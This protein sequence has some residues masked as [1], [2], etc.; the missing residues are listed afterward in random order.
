MSATLE[1][2]NDKVIQLNAAVDEEKEKHEKKEAE[3]K[4]A[5]EDEKEKHKN[6]MKE[7]HEKH[8][9][10]IEHKDDDHKTK[11]ESLRASLKAQMDEEKDEKKKEGLKAALKAMED[12]HKKH[13][14]DD[15]TRKLEEKE[16]KKARYGEKEDDEEKK[17]LK[18]EVT[19]LSAAVNT[20]KIDY[21]KQVYTAAKTPESDLTNYM[22]EWSAMT[23]IQLDA[24]IKKVE[25]LLG[26]M[27]SFEASTEK[28]SPFGFST[29]QAPSSHEYSA[30][31]GLDK[32]DKMTDKDLFSTPG[33]N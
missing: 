1:E 4:K 3:H 20:P 5:M 26:H 30:A 16:G 15:K 19:Y 33:V 2:L 18:A 8:E 6:A 14:G 32:I 13:E 12:E 10:E 27:K 11:Y 21:L 17:A 28:K 9:S 22:K 25:P 29:G 7:E 24:A 23:S 31:K